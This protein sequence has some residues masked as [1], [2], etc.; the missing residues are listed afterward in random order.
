[1]L[2]WFRDWGP[3]C[4]VALA[5][6]LCLRL[7]FAWKYGEVLGDTVVYGDIARNWLQHGVYGVSETS[8]AGVAGI[9]PTLMRLPGYPLFLLVLFVLFGIGKYSAVLAVQAVLDLWTCCL[10]AGV[11]LRL[12]GGRAAR[13][14][15]ILGALCPFLANYAGMA[16]TETPTLWCI[17]LAFYAFV[18]WQESG[19]WVN[20]WVVVLGF[21][22][23][24]AVLLRPEQGMLAAVVVPGMAWVGYRRGG[25]GWLRP[26]VL[27]AVLTVLPLVPWTVRNWMTFH[28]VQ[29][30]APRYANDPKEW[31][32]YGF[33]RWYR[34]WAVDFH[35]TDRVYWQFDG[36]EISIGDIPD[37]AF[38][39][40]DQRART[41]ALLD[42]YNM[43]TTPSHAIDDGFAALAAERVKA[44]P[45][46]Y[47]LILPMAR[48]VNA[49]FH[50]RVDQLPVPLEWWKYRL[51]P[52]ETCFAWGYVGLNLAYV[53]LG[54]V[55][56][57]RRKWKPQWGILVT[58]MVVT[59]VFRAALLLT[60]DNSEP[61]YTLEFYPALIVFASGVVPG[62]WKRANASGQ[63]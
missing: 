18:R 9:R 58:V 12:F 28:V 32:P 49:T 56:L 10:L 35:S 31:N 55:G 33:Q 37:R 16:L 59:V 39:S 20:R 53:T 40:A 54:V 19:G 11:A 22:L 36:G 50:P 26:A 17:A 24:W 3:W 15:L 42:Q 34:T 13:A 63:A 41:A 30:L 21:A 38:D 61:R 25:A 48:L 1:M 45:V 43:T 52:A 51:H 4:G 2:A 23:A 5:V 6:G 8:K 7:W 44:H 29:P 57:T 46:R 47:Y 27:A 60:V 62:W 14:A